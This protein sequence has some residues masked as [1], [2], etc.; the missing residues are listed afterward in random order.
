MRARTLSVTC[1]SSF[2]GFSIDLTFELCSWTTG[3][4]YTVGS[5]LWPSQFYRGH[6]CVGVIGSEISPAFLEISQSNKC[7]MHV[8]REIRREYKDKKTDHNMAQF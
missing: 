6:A 3:P 5:L 8:H 7:E 4:P 1:L 2:Q